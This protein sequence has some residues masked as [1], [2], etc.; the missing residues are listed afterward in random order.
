MNMIIKLSSRNRRILFAFA[1]KI[2]D[3]GNWRKRDISQSV[4]SHSQGNRAGTLPPSLTCF[5]TWTHSLTSHLSGHHLINPVL[6]YSPQF[7]PHHCWNHSFTC[8]S[9]KLHCKHFETRDSFLHDCLLPTSSFSSCPSS[10]LPN[11][12]IEPAS[13]ISPASAAGFLTP[14]ATWEVLTACRLEAV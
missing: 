2:F 1:I 3:V 13:L 6:V 11:P 10:D 9:P 14:G 7:L 12:R 8:F 4:Q 5:M